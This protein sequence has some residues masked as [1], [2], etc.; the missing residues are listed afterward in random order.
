MSK[1]LVLVDYHSF[2]DVITNSS[3]ELF[4]VSDDKTVEFV[5]EVL[6][7]MCKEWNRLALKGFFGSWHTRNE[8]PNLNGSEK[9]EPT[10]R[11]FDEMFEYPYIYTQEMFDNKDQYAWDYER[12]ENVGKI[13]IQGTTD[14]SIPYEVMEWIGNYFSAEREHLG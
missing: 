5:N 7:D 4:V 1:Q 12:G 11:P 13:I 14:N 9:E 8:R 3:T 6:K 2:I 10:V